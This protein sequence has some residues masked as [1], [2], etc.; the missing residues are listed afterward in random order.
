MHNI[1][2]QNVVESKVQVPENYTYVLINM[3]L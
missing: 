1:C 2:L 3:Y